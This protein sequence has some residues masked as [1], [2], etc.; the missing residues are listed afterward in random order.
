MRFIEE[1]KRRNVFRV[2]VAYAIA[3]WVLLQIADLV[4]GNIEAPRWV[5]KVFMLALAIGFP[6]AL[7]F[8]WAY[9]LT[10]DG[11]KREKDV[12][13]AKSITGQT[14]RKLDRWIIVILS[15]AVVY[16]AWDRFVAAPETPTP[17][18]ATPVT[19]EE[20]ALAPVANP[21]SLAVLPFV[22]MS[23]GPDD[24]YFADGLTEEILNSLT[25]LPEL[26]VTARTSSF[27]FK[28]QD[29]PVQEIAATLGVRHI[30]EGSVRRS[31]DRL[32]VTAQLIRASDGFR[33]WSENY[34]STSGDTIQIQEDI[35]EKIV[36]AMD[37]VM[38]DEKRETMRRAGLRNVEAFV[39][40]QKAQELLEIAHDGK[41][42]QIV[43]LRRA[44][45]QLEKVIE[46]VPTFPTAFIDHSDLY[47][48]ML[49]RASLGRRDQGV[50]QR[51]LEEAPD[52]IVAD[53]TMAVENA[54][55]LSERNNI[56]LL[57][58]FLSGDW[59]GM[60]D[61]VERFLAEDDCNRAFWAIEIVTAF[62]LA[63][64][65]TQRAHQ[66][67]KC[68]PMISISWQ[69]E[70]NAY[71]WAGNAEEAVKVAS[72]GLEIIPNRTSA[73]AMVRALIT[74][75]RYEEAD[76]AIAN[77]QFLVEADALKL[78]MLKSAAIG[79]LDGSRVLHAQ[80]LESAYP[81][82]TRTDA[83]HAWVGDRENANRRA[84]EIDSQ[85]FGP[86]SLL[87]LTFWCA[88]GAPFDLEATPVFAAR[89]ESANMPWPPASPIKFPLK[90]W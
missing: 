38:D 80:L 56:E 60:R 46:L 45:E 58:A 20:P 55:S 50:T 51:D 28:G 66:I 8:A 43:Y 74:S 77:Q 59:H 22:A 14:A 11:I 62:G 82:S 19:Q 71:L 57:L 18:E 65:Y 63:N 4:L 25:Q 79:D 39:L 72:E 86:Q 87:F 17:V 78:R 81:P 41:S 44:N 40:Y 3:A 33:L 9:E 83:F 29:I 64:D 42:D 2:G 32:R 49:L 13:R 69:E 15:I 23:N 30:V 88:C 35:A 37:V 73:I 90:D 24:E 7:F 31:G 75:G 52:R 85:P 53:L 84:A 36:E 68:D 67:R 5:M 1:L 61:N 48:H 12:D 54:R 6:M 16:F 27:Y 34:D 10:P 89:I 47:A 26:L 21:R 76:H 70:A